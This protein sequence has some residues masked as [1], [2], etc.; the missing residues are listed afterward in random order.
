MALVTSFI[1]LSGSSGECVVCGTSGA[2]GYLGKKGITYYCRCD[3]GT[4]DDADLHACPRCK[5][6]TGTKAGG[7]CHAC[8][9]TV[10]RCSTCGR[11]QYPGSLNASGVC[12]SCAQ[13]KARQTASAPPPPS[14]TLCGGTHAAA[15]CRHKCATVGCTQKR[16]YSRQY[17]S[18]HQPAPK[19]Q[20]PRTASAGRSFRLF[21]YP[22]KAEWVLTGSTNELTRHH[23]T[24]LEA[25][26]AKRADPN[27][28]V[29]ESALAAVEALF[30]LLHEQLKVEPKP[31]ERQ[32][33]KIR[34]KVDY[35]QIFCSL[36]GTQRQA[37]TLEVAKREYRRMVVVLHPDRGGD[38][39]KMADLNV[40]WG[41][42]RNALAQQSTP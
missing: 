28:A 16:L 21:Y 3:G 18:G 23:I 14:C 30:A 41:H 40:A 22:P 42:V 20:A 6:L 13:A 19:P 2:D 33:Q 24:V 37:L 17:C 12:I 5:K 11:S 15:T 1:Q 7:R 27:L 4:L 35:I 32:I 38:S 26:G 39:A 10:V 29:P 36:T 31:P 8:A 9:T 25:L 34:P